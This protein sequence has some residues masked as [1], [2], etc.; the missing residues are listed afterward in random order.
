MTLL[1]DQGPSMT[2]EEF[3]LL[4]DLVN[5]FCGISFDRDAKFVVER[6]LRERLHALGLDSYTAYY[7]RLRFHP[8]GETELE[9]AVDLLTTNET[10]FFREA[11]QLEVIDEEELRKEQRK[12]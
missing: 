7:E 12:N 3:R 5:S 10:Y 6:R 11:Y 2:P 8:D 9:R 1:F 4:R